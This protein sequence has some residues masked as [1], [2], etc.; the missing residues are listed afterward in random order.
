[1]HPP[2][3]T[4]RRSRPQ[5]SVPPPAH[6]ARAEYE[7]RVTRGRDQPWHV[8]RVVGEVA[9]HLEDELGFAGEEMSEPCDV[10]RPDSFLL[11]S[12]QYGDPRELAREAIGDLPGSV[13]RAVVDHEDAIARRVQDLTEGTHHR[14]QVLALVVGGQADDGS[15]HVRIIAAWRSLCPGT[16][17]SPTSSTS[18][19]TSRRSWPRSRS[20]SSRTGAQRRASARRRACRG[21]RACRES[22]R[23]P[24]DRQDD[25]AEG[26]RDRHGR[27]DARAHAA[28]R[29]GAAGRRRLP[30]PSGRRAEDGRPDLDRARS[31]DARRA[32]DGRRGRAAAR[33]LRHGAEERGE[34]PRGPRGGCGEDG[35]EGRPGPAGTRAPRSPR[36]RGA[37]LR[38]WRG[39]RG[40]G[41]GKRPATQGDRSRSR[42]NRHVVRA[43][44][45]HRG[46]LR[47]R[48]GLGGRGTRG[49]EG[50]GRGTP[51]SSLRSPG[52]AARVLRQRPAALH[53]VE[54]PQRR[55]ARGRPASR[56]LDLRVRSHDRRDGRGRDPCDRGGALRVPRVRLDPAG[57]ARVG[58]RA[59]RLPASTRFP[60]SSS[61]RTC[62]ARCIATRRGLPTARARSRRWRSSRSAGATSTCA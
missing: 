23:P 48:L 28:P 26:R 20:R 36:H 4:K 15:R 10:R 16:P 18:S 59:R 9:V 45:T 30:A 61:S 8:A 40:V 12:V 34:D 24:R 13:R 32:E 1:M 22:N 29:E 46:V 50:D 35:S 39:H 5:F 11:R 25:R 33:P 41:G 38:A 56:S 43:A 3:E 51:G 54:G 49:H 37:A 6:V 21:A 60:S 17:R 55:L 62:A 19:R 52:R 53:R 27:G 2:R 47:G 42:L 7:I 44:V 31:H 57:A 14:L 58:R